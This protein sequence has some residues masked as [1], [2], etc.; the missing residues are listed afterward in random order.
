[1]CDPAICLCTRPQVLE[2]LPVLAPLP[3][4]LAA[5]PA[6]AG[7]AAP[8][9]ALTAAVAGP[10]A[11]AEDW[12]PALPALRHLQPAKLAVYQAV[13]QQGHG[14]EAVAAAKNIRLDSVQVR[15]GWGWGA[16]ASQAAAMCWRALP[17]ILYVGPAGA[18]SCPS[19]RPFPS[20]TVGLPG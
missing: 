18:Q 4:L 20:C 3:P 16:G 1:M 17:G 14:M 19:L 11:E 2:K 8:A 7:A 9:G 6:P 12:V 13:V 10:W 5:C 15:A